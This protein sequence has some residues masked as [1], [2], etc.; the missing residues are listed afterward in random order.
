M[1]DAGR[2]RKPSLKFA[3]SSY[4]PPDGPESPAPFQSD[5]FIPIDPSQLA[6]PQEELRRKPSLLRKASISSR[7]RSQ[8]SLR[9]RERERGEQR[10]LTSIRLE[11]LKPANANTAGDSPG[12]A[13]PRGQ[14]PWDNNHVSGPHTGNAL[15]A[16]GVSARGKNGSVDQHG[17]KEGCKCL[18]M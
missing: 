12:H 5:R 17:K 16:P 3:S 18:I 11:D 1:L 14:Q 9:D 4:V 13:Q 2:S 15:G 10:D 6:A 8:Q 7:Q